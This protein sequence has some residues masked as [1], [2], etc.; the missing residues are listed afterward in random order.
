[1]TTL[2]VG[3]IDARAVAEDAEAGRLLGDRLTGLLTQAAHALEGELPYVDERTVVCVRRLDVALALD[4]DTSDGT[5]YAWAR[6]I[7]RT[8][9]GVVD[10]GGRR[11]VATAGTGS[12]RVEVVEYPDRG[13]ALADLVASLAVGE[14]GRAWAWALVGL[15][16]GA[17]PEGRA[18]V[19]QDA[20][21]TAALAALAEHPDSAATAV[22]AAARTTGLA[23]VHRLLGHDGWLALAARLLETQGSRLSIAELADV[24]PFLEFVPVA[25]PFAEVAERCGLVVPMPT[26]LAWA[27][28]ALAD[29]RPD[30]LTEAQAR[31]LV[32]GLAAELAAAARPADARHDSPRPTAAGA[33]SDAVEADEPPV[34]DETKRD[35][36]L[37]TSR[38]GLLFLLTVAAEAGL[39]DLALDDPRVAGRN[40]TWVLANLALRLADSVLDDPAVRVFAGLD[41]QVP[42][43]PLEAG[44][45]DEEAVLD[46][47]A[48]AWTAAAARRLR[49]G[50][51]ASAEED[52]ELVRRV[53]DRDGL[54]VSAPGW[55]DVVLDAAEVDV[56]VRRAGLDLDPGFV[57]WLGTVV[58][59][60]YE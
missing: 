1:M 11:R 44:L 29:A 7:G 26:A 46:D 28:V 60:R 24:P 13:A 6:T 19:S 48:A 55:V 3:R 40:A 8:I 45:P 34:P 25:T 17:D 49:E 9:A 42:V 59:F 2:F 27:V 58:R 14:R 22:V 39:P 57:P 50:R 10:G 47:A 30:L 36:G 56:D 4:D 37:P 38:A 5:A 18:L 31:T 21:R 43:A 20:R 35:S 23:A 53:V 32:V 33:G 12:S 54:V 15:T 51:D 41:T 52:G 16:D